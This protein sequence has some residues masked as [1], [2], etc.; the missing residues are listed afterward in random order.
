MCFNYK[1][2]VLCCTPNYYCPQSTTPSRAPSTISTAS[3]TTSYT[4][5]IPTSTPCFCKIGDDVYSPGDVIYNRMDS[6]G[7]RFYAICSQA[8]SVERY[9][10]PCNV[11]T[12]VT[13][14]SPQTPTVTTSAPY[15]PSGCVSSTYPPLQPGQRYKLS[16]CTEIICEGDNKIKVVQ[17][18][19]PP[20]KEISCAN[21]Y[22]PILVPDENRCCY[23]YEC[24]CV[25]SGWGDPHYITFDGTYYTFLEN[26]TYVLVKQIV[27]KYDNFRVYIDNYY[28]DSKDG[29]SCPKS[30]IIFYKSAEVVLTRELMNGVMT[31]VMYFNKKIV[32]PGFKKDGIYFSTLGI[33][34]IVEIPEIGATIT[35]SGLIF[36]VKLPYSKF[37]NNTEGQCGTCTN[38]KADECRL[39]SG[40]IISSCPQMAHHWLV[41]NNTP[42]HGV[43]PPT[44]I[45][46]PPPRPQCKVPELCKI[47][48]SKVFAKCHD[49]IPP[50]P[51]FKGCV[52]DGCRMTEE[53]MQC[54]SLEIYATECG[55]RG[56]CIDWRGK[57]N[58]ICPYNC[59]A[60]ME[61]K[62]CGSI[63]P[64]TCE[65]SSVD[66]PGYGVTEGC[67]CPEG[68]TLLS[69]DSSI[70]VSECSCREPNGVYRGPGEKWT[71]NCQECVCDRYTLR[72]Q[73]TKHVCSMPQQKAC[74][75]PGYVPVQIQIPEDPCC[76][77]TECYCNTSLCPEATHQC[78]EGQEIITVTQPG[79]CCPTFECRH[80]CVV[81]ET[82]YAPGAVIPSGPCETCTCS[83]S[84]YS[85]LQQVAVKCQPVICDTYC[86]MGYKYTVEPGKCCGTCKAEACIVN[87]GDNT[88]H[89]LK[90][91][92]YWNQPGNNCT[93]YTCEKHNGQFITVIVKK[94]CPYFNADDCDPN[95]IKLSDDGC[96]RECSIVPTGCKKHNTT[97]VI[98]H[99]GC[100]SPAPVEMTYCE[101]SCDAYSRYS[102]EANMMEHKCSCCQEVQTSIRKVTLMCSDGTHLDHSYTYVEQCS[103]VGAECVPQD[104]VNQQQ[105]TGNI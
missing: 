58:N 5:S 15:P 13:T 52:F 64:A 22:P 42:C 38:N 19:C 66:H 72:V 57:T 16:N 7:C 88:T 51:F 73:C 99:R 62:P 36:S 94:T 20:V 4:T 90:I 89:V 49:V 80:G 92:E 21:K 84:S 67:F 1:I 95:T 71:T 100:V 25:C 26:C 48:L 33:N 93:A 31:N 78:L 54:S 11:T 97:T 59:P 63:N 102:Q 24:Q 43:P 87:M 14:T 75:E 98:K 2:R 17:T 53:S 69:E 35:F 91:G 28:C 77:R 32:Q 30:I 47:I 68:T 41:G 86:P 27:P 60:N 82:Y 44:L 12:P 46:T 50:E 29:L 61:Y 9:T 85:S 81:N 23:H 83:E 8:C 76:T 39:P 101:G 104:I 56:V 70:C 55:S 6:D 45:T 18:I 37:G 105:Q 96:C 79:K 34:M 103:C 40:K 3:E 10:G 74:Y 65:P